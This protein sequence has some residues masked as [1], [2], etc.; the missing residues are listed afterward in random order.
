MARTI[1]TP[2][3]PGCVPTVQGRDATNLLPAAG[4]VLHIGPSASVQFIRPIMFRVIRAH[5]WTTYDGW[6]WLDGYQINEAGDATE[7]RSLFVQIDGLRK[8]TPAAL[9]PRPRN[10]R[11]YRQPAQP[12][13]QRQECAA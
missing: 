6:V 11:T 7:R 8:A 12:T 9:V 1:G 2:V 4:D 10:S 5:D 13:R 3:K